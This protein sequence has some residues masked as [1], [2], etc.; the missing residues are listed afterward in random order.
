[1]R[2]KEAVEIIHSF[3]AALLLMVED[4]QARMRA[5]ALQGLGIVCAKGDVTA[6]NRVSQVHPPPHP[7]PPLPSFPYKVDTSRPPPPY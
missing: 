7:P 2:S 1:V 6:L 3:R 4:R 5:A